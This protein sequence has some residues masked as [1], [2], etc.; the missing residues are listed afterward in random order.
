MRN[1]PYKNLTGLAFFG[2]A[3]CLVDREARLPADL[4][5]AQA[6]AQWRVVGVG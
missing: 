1:A 2:W 5:K 3:Q 4:W 6:A